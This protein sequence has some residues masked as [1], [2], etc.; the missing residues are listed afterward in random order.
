[1]LVLGR[2][3]H[4]LGRQGEPVETSCSTEE[5]EEAGVCSIIGWEE[6]TLAC[7]EHRVGLTSKAFLWW[8]GSYNRA[9]VLTGETGLDI[10]QQALKTKEKAF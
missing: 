8:K 7:K 3:K 6:G 5:E 10:Q 1:V 2:A 4:Q 9:G